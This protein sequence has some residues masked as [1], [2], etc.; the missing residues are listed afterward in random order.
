MENQSLLVTE[1]QIFIVFDKLNYICYLK[2][3]TKEVENTILK[4]LTILS[5]VTV[6]W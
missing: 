5:I 4:V 2:V 1:V 6:N 3:K